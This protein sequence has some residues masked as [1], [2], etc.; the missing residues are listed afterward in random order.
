MKCKLERLPDISEEEIKDI[1]NKVLNK[2]VDIVFLIDATGSMGSEIAAAKDM[3][4]KSLK[5]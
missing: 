2:D 4:L 1:K 3:F 5:N